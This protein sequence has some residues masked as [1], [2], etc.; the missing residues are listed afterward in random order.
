MVSSVGCSRN[1]WALWSFALPLLVATAAGPSG[2]AAVG[3]LRSDLRVIVRYAE[4]VAKSVSKTQAAAQRLRSITGVRRVKALGHV[5]MAVATCA[6]VD[7]MEQLIADLAR[8]PAVELAVPDSAVWADD[9]S[10]LFELVDDANL[11]NL[12]NIDV[13]PSSTTAA[14]PGPRR[15]PNDPLF[16]KLWGLHGEL[17]TAFD[18]DAPEAWATFTG[19][20]STGI[21]VGVIDT[22]ID[23]NHEDLRGQMWTN[24]AEIPGN[25]IDDDGNGYVDDIHGANF[26]YNSGDPMD[27]NIHGT[28][29]AGTIA[30]VGD[31][32]VG[33]T[34]VAWRGVKLMALKFLGSDG[35]GRASDAIAAVDYA[36]AHGARITSNSW[37][38]G[39]SN[40]AM[41]VAI[42]RAE[43]AGML[44]IAAAGNSATNND[45]RPHYPSNYP[46][47][48]VISVA[49]T[50]RSGTLSSF[51]CYGL[52]TVHVAAP[53]S[54]IV[55]CA[56]G[57]RYKSLSG[58]SMATPQV[59]G[60]AAL[61][62]MYRPYLL[63]S[64]VKEILLSTAVRHTSLHGRIV[65]GGQVNAKEALDA[66]SRLPVSR[67][68]IHAPRGV[69]FRD[70]DGK[71]GK[72]A[73]AV[74]ITI[75]SDESDVEF[76][77]VYIVSSAGFPLYCLGTVPARGTVESEL[78]LN[79]SMTIPR[80]ANNIAVVSCN[81]TSRH[82]PHHTHHVHPCYPP[83]S[84]TPFAHP[85]THPA[86]F[87]STLT[88]EHL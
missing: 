34:G 25:G 43:A 49:S 35:S 78:L 62:W 9:N 79:V 41:R 76:Y 53:G 54:N 71:L 27:D 24:V 13:E 56:P 30:A 11:T 6:D 22:G 48:N 83:P 50:Q 45:E 73:G 29:C 5:G 67:P 88:M 51:S 59:S 87:A 20:N 15:F 19:E 31:N 4:V 86:P 33:V 85:L 38:G 72:M 84:P 26:A 69:I 57:N 65:T 14:P 39:P 52:R 74:I 8:N 36:V 12:T 17:T 63:N 70:T 77:K 1:F 68:P 3:T 42:E 23:Y 16:A 7:V 55:S 10:N 28:H 44:F 61:V 21:I 75:A 32:G 40:S 64:Q 18:I 2:K 46:V 58:T 82:T 81:R 60:I 80:Y 66:A 47:S 37:G